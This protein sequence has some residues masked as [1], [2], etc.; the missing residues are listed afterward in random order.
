MDGYEATRGMQRLQPQQSLVCEVGHCLS[1]KLIL[2][3]RSKSAE[4]DQRISALERLLKE[5]RSRDC[6][7][8]RV[9]EEIG[10][11]LG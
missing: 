8:C 7:P 1:K 5:M 6:E 4:G 11:C 10:L 2:Y 3:L 9:F